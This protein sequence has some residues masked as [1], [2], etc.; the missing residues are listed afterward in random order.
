MILG[1][2]DI[3]FCQQEVNNPVIEAEKMLSGEQGRGKEDS[4]YSRGGPPIRRYPHIRRYPDI[5]RSK[6][7]G[8]TWKLRSEHGTND[9]ASPTNAV[10]LL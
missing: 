6:E 8:E 10:I 5:R 1:T 7:L 4:E 3:S 9:A 2:Y